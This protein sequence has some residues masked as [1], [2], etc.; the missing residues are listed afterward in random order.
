MQKN[1]DTIQDKKQKD[2]N[3]V[4]HNIHSSTIKGNLNDSSTIKSHR[5]WPLQSS[6]CKVFVFSSLQA[7]TSRE[8]QPELSDR[9]WSHHLVRGYIFLCYPHHRPASCGGTVQYHSLADSTGLLSLLWNHSC[10]D[11]S[12]VLHLWQPHTEKK[13]ILYNVNLASSQKK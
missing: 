3:Y 11:G 8:P 4:L 1:D 2:C 6:V 9:N 7:S 10:Q 5:P 13:G 12:S